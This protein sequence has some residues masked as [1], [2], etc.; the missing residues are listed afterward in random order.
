[1][2]NKDNNRHIV[3]GRGCEFSTNQESG[4]PIATNV[5]GSHK[6]HSFNWSAELN[7][8]DNLIFEVRFKNTRK[9]FYEN[10]NNL[11]LVCGDVVAVESSPGHDIGI[12]SLTGDMVGRQMRASGFDPNKFEFKKIY[13]KA[14]PADIEKWQEAIALEHNTMIR[15][16]QIAASL[17]L[18][19]KIGDVEY[20]G[21]KVKAIFYYIADARIDF[22]TL[23][24]LLADEFKIR[25]EM[26]QI[27][28]R[29]EAGRIGG[30]GGC[31]RELCCST[32]VKN[33][34]SVTTNAARHQ[35]IL[36]NPQ[37]L[38]GQCGKLKCCLNFEVD[39]YIDARKNFPRVHH[40]LE[41]KDAI[42]YLIKS[43][44]F[45]GEMSFSSE[46]GSMANL[47]T[48]DINRVREIMQ[49]NRKGEKPELLKE[50]VEEMEVA[51][52]PDY[53][54][55]IG[56]D[57]ITRFDKQGNVNGGNRRNRNKSRNRNVDKEAL[58]PHTQATTPTPKERR[59]KDKPL[60][61]KQMREEVK[62]D[63]KTGVKT[64]VKADVK[65]DI[66]PNRNRGRKPQSRPQNSQPTEN[67]PSTHIASE[68]EAAVK[69]QHI[70][71]GGVRPNDR[72]RR[73]NV[74]HEG[75]APS[76]EKKEGNKE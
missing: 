59:I 58:A 34:V 66:K 31:G 26:K 69:P 70:S 67:K 49:M 56:D 30:I 28:A 46:Q 2:N 61:E 3:V 27:G 54:N 4:E 11:T 15:S 68:K 43:D 37:K 65:T 40:P 51:E 7:P 64:D 42:Y 10:V 38:A 39:S 33:F 52:L 19:M 16:R 41:T 23:I 36:L 8:N 6:L 74:R 12:I 57:S 24:K 1:M 25:I 29:Q 45:K 73:P 55:V 48:I 18:D 32:W 21:D 17:D 5:E 22:R 47:I 53:R 75:N 14:K 63:V 35:E 44:I 9:G 50:E 72:R 71:H 62:T 13:R 20:Q 60:R 76:S